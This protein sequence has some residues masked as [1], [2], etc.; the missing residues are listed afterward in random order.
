M[1]IL[2]VYANYPEA[3][4]QPTWVE[5]VRSLNLRMRSSWASTTV[6]MKPWN[7]GLPR[8]NDGN[9]L[10]AGVAD[11]ALRINQ[12]LKLLP[13]LLKNPSFNLTC[14][15]SS[16]RTIHNGPRAPPSP[17]MGLMTSTD[18]CSFLRAVSESLTA[19]DAVARWGPTTT[20][21]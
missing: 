10:M 3:G 11:I 16:G 15:H 13:G 7:G 12:V 2:Q 5:L 9:F 19:Q 14:I 21:P 20:L 4:I 8:G 17:S 1:V 6:I 18:E